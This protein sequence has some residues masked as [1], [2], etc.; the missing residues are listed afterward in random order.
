[1]MIVDEEK[2]IGCGL[3]VKDCFPKDIE[4]IGG[5]AHINN[6]TCFKCGHCMFFAIEKCNKMQC[7]SVT[8]F[9]AI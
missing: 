1:M 7:K 4:M 5:K 6:V 9:L 3:C 8:P 2:C